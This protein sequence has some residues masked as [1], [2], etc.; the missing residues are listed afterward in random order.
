MS[1][2]N[3]ISNTREEKTQVDPEIVEVEAKRKVN[4]RSNR[5]GIVIHIV[6]SN[7]VKGDSKE[8]IATPYRDGAL[9]YQMIPL[10]KRWSEFL[11]KKCLLR[12]NP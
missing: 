1:F 6:T 5:A 9:D 4:T 8:K 11:Y 3:F 2:K 7:R 12:Q 10:I